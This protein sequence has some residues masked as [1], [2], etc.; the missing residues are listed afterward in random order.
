M[1]GYCLVNGL[2]VRHY[3]VLLGVTGVFDF[4]WS[5]LLVKVGNWLLS[6]GAMCVEV[7]TNMLSSVMDV[8]VNLV[9]VIMV[10][11]MSGVVGAVALSQVVSSMNGGV[12]SQ[13][14]LVCE[15]HVAPM[16]SIVGSLG[17]WLLH[18]ESLVIVMVNVVSVREWHLCHHSFVVG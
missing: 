6:M 17:D 11:W 2:V 10:D 8:I 3:V 16:P 15:V 9:V 7:L 1:M 18:I 14:C 5:F 4:K 12:V 13:G